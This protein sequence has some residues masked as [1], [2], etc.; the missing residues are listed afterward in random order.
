MAARR[1]LKF[2][3]QSEGSN[4]GQ[5]TIDQLRAEIARLAQAYPRQPLP[6]VLFDLSEVQDVAFRLLEGRQRPD[7]SK[8]MYLLAGVVSGM[9]A[10]ASHDMGDPHSALTQARASF[11]CADNAGHDGL[12]AWTRGLQSLI[13]YWAGWPQEAARY[14]AGGAEFA[15]RTSG[16]AS[17]WLPAQEGRALAVLGD[18]EGALAAIQRAKDAREAAGADD[19]DDLGGIMTFPGP[20][21][22]YYTADTLTWLPGDEQRADQTAAEALAAYEAADPADRAFGD[23]AGARADQALAR[24]QM[25]DLDGA[26]EA[27]RPVLDLPMEMR[28]AGIVASA[29]RVHDALRGP[30]FGGVLAR[31]LREEIEQYGQ[32]SVR[33]ALPPG[34]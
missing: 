5:E 10:K 8:E 13:C 18:R 28:N 30:E 25:S 3:S 2:L 27:L 12:R 22:I 15:R 9:L 7:Q 31:G 11:V 6:T 4:V 14:A 33:A 32:V 1:A 20:R 24:V 34:R 16:T 29:M 26:A 19:L 23:E 21:Q 17:V